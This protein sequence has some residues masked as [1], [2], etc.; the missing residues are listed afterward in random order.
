MDSQ[1]LPS[2][3]ND[4]LTFRRF[5]IAAVG[6]I[7]ALIVG[8]QIPDQPYVVLAGLGAFAYLF[9]LA[10]NYRWLALLMVALQPAALIMPFFP[11]RPYMWEVCAFLSWPSLLVS[12]LVNRRRLPE[13]RFDRF[14]TSAML[15]LVGYI[16]VLICLMLSR[17]VGFRVLGGGQMGGRFYVQQVMLSVVPILMLMASPRPS[18]LLGAVV[19]GWVLSLTY[20]ISDFAL[21]VGGPR[22]YPVLQFFELPTDAINFFIG[23]ELTGVRRYQSL[24]F[25]GSAVISAACTLMTLKDIV[26]RRIWL[27]LPMVVGGLILALGSGHRTVVVQTVTSLFVLAW[28]QRFWSPSRAIF[29]GGLLSVGV[30]ALYISAPNMPLSLQRSVSF[31][32]GINI[33]SQADDNATDTIRD[34]L[35]VLKMAAHDIPKYWLIGRGFGMERFDKIDP[36]ENT[37]GVYQQYANGLFYNGI[38][39]SLVK[40]GIP[41]LVT[42]LLFIFWVSRM[43]I[44]LVA[45]IRRKSTEEWTL[46]DRLG[47]FISAQWFA[48][49][50]FFYF[51]HGDSAAWMQ[52]FGVPAALILA[53]RRAVQT[54]DAEPDESV[55]Q[56]V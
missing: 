5:I 38:I 6:V 32:P 42:S 40:T 22:F 44:D 26:G 24:W 51:L 55:A 27:G 11:G 33:S 48:F 7:V 35:E 46:L 25:V 52:G 2:S 16:V 18:A 19:A 8:I 56:S 50:A 37:D 4:P 14:E 49:V 23:Y 53:C 54:R 15:S 34:R 20:L 43:A 31:L 10:V 9:T 30:I 41:G 29:A 1:M 12:Y 36:D 21:A 39:G 28:F 47:L 13:L 3:L 17:G 45:T